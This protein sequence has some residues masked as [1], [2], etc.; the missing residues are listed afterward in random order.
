MLG[1]T[2]HDL[3]GFEQQANILAQDLGYVF[4]HS[5]IAAKPAT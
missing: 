1:A 5:F 4:L 3:P 2:Q